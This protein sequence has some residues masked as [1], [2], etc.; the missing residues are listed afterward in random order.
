MGGPKAY[1]DHLIQAHISWKDTGTQIANFVVENIGDVN[2]QRQAN[3]ERIKVSNTYDRFNYAVK[4]ADESTSI[5]DEL[6]TFFQ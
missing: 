2:G 6:K 5:Q 1:V 4:P 3:K